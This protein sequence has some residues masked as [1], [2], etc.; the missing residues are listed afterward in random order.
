MS[1]F[2]DGVSAHAPVRSWSGG[3]VAVG[4]PTA[5]CPSGRTGHSS[6]NGARRATQQWRVG[7]W[8]HAVV[9]LHH[10]TH[11]QPRKLGSASPFQLPIPAV[12]FHSAKNS[13]LVFDPRLTNPPDHPSPRGISTDTWI[14]PHISV[15]L[16]P[17]LRYPRDPFW[18]VQPSKHD[19]ELFHSARFTPLT[20]SIP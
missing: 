2:G 12:I 16:T 20:E 9:L 10:S 13:T 14:V 8:R 1:S 6:R 5:N 7:D 4:A 17:F 18:C 3:E 15:P 19:W 11:P